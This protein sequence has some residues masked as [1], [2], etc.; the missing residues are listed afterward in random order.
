MAQASHEALAGETVKQRRVH[1]YSRDLSIL[2]VPSNRQFEIVSSESPLHAEY[3]RCCESSAHSGD[4]KEDF[5]CTCRD[6]EG[7]GALENKRTPVGEIERMA[8]E[9]LAE[10]EDQAARREDIFGSSSLGGGGLGL[11]CSAQG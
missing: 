9:V 6:E 3:V 11:V 5:V 4:T 7:E 10:V 8:L 1:R 2:A